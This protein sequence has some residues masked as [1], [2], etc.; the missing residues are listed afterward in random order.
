MTNAKEDND[1]NGN[2]NWDNDIEAEP[3]RRVM[4]YASTDERT[5]GQSNTFDATDYCG[6]YRP[7]FE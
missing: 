1:N 3:P 5:Q 6:I 2:A 7:V 4:G